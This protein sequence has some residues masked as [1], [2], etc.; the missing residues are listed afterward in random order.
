MAGGRDD[1]GDEK[2]S[3]NVLLPQFPGE[4]F[5]AHQG[6]AWWEQAEAVLSLHGLLAVA[7]GHEPEACQAIVD[8][9][10]NLLPA[11]PVTDREHN[12]R[13]EKRIF[14]MAQNKANAR[15]RRSIMLSQWTKIYVLYCK[16]GMDFDDSPQ[17]I[18]THL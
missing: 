15:K 18:P 13:H 5:L 10:L 2:L 3:S 17:Y 9:D 6:T 12:R 11:L 14:A 1:P 16:F 7:N 8:V 4:D